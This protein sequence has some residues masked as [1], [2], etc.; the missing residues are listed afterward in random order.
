VVTNDKLEFSPS[1]KKVGAENAKIILGPKGRV[2]WRL[3][4]AGRIE[5]SSDG[6]VNWVAQNSGVNVELIGGSAP[7]NTVCWIFGR[8]GT[9]L[10]TTDGGSHWTKVPWPDAGEIVGIQGL[11]AMHAIVYEGSLGLPARLAT[12]D[13]GETWFRTNK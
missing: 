10:K 12:N 9:I 1:L 11:D 6:G 4:S 7:S 13:G 8:G 3:L 5:R 2:R